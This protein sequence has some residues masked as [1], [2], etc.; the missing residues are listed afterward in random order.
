MTEKKKRTYDI[1]K[2]DFSMFERGIH[3]QREYYKQANLQNDYQTMFKC[4]ENIFV[5]IKIKIVKRGNKEDVR[6]IQKILKWYKTLELRYQKRTEDG[7]K[8]IYPSNIEYI[9]SI[10]V[11]KAYELIIKNL[12]LLALI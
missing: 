5:E 8:L 6:E 10:K 11:S 7:M 1:I 12:N 9:T 2:D 3:L 4:I